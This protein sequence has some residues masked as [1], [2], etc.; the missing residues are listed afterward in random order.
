M[1]SFTKH[2]AALLICCVAPTL[3]AQNNAQQAPD[4]GV[5]LQVHVNSVLVPVVVR[6]AQ[7]HAIGD[8]K[9]E[10]FKVLDQ[11]KTRPITG[12]TVQQGAAQQGSAAPVAGVNTAGQ[13]IAAKAQAP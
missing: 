2:F 13:P 1:S 12:F 9:Q 6:D 5:T 11:G 10:D 8:L 3:G 7:G 4:S